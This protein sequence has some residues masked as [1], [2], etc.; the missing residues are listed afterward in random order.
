LARAGTITTSHG[1]IHTP[2]FVAV[3]TKATVKSLNPEQVKDIGVEM[4]LGNTYHLY[5]QPGDETVR[6]AGGIGKFM[7]WPGP[8]MTDSGG[9]QVF[10]LGAAYGKGVSKITTITTPEPLLRKEGR[11]SSRPAKGEWPEAEGV[12]SLAKVDDDGVSFKSHL[13]GSIHYIAPEKSIQIQYNLGA[14]I[15]FAFDECTSP[16]EDLKYQA[17]ALERTHR[18]AERS[19]AE[20]QRICSA[21]ENIFSRSS[22]T[23]S[24]RDGTPP[25]VASQKI[26]SSAAKPVTDFFERRVGERERQGEKISNGVA[27]FGIVQ[28]GREESLRKKSAKIIAKTNVDGKYFDGFG[29]GGSF[30]KKDMSSAVKWV[31]EILPEDKPRHLLGIGEPEDL[32]MGVENGVDL[33]DCVAPTRLGRNG[34]LYT[35]SGKIII[36]NKQYRNDYSPVEKDCGCYTCS[37][38]LGGAGY[39]KAYLAHLFHGKEMLAG[40]L[41]SIHNLY[42]IVNLVKNIRQSILDGTFFDFKNKFLYNYRN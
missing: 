35:K 14:D 13:D 17:E 16:A 5:L 8:T 15:I 32:F 40:T 33:F 3:G 26:F 25:P 1:V 21:E 20:H 4:V 36:M 34:T 19:L 37:P 12:G 42:F 39:T 27:I 41:A 23:P 24:L 10:S 7:N 29:I 31:N 6:E 28:G 11:N 22:L 9:F 38:R 30:A 18:W 2:A